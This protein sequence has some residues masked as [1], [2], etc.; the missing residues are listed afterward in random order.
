MKR[1]KKLITLRVV[2]C[3]K[4]DSTEEK[5]SLQSSASVDDIRNKQILCFS[6]W[7]WCMTNLITYVIY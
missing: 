5:Y 4:A 1:R 3:Q 6:S 7:Q 2:L